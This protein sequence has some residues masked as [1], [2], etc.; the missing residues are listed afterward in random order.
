VKKAKSEYSI[1]TVVNAFGV[2]EAFASEEELGVSELS[3][4]LRLHKNNVFRILATLE[5]IGYI[6][7]RDGGRYR[8]GTR[9]L[10]L[11][12]WFRCAGGDL[13]RRG[14]HALEQ[15]ARETG[16]TVHLGVL[17]GFDVVHLDGVD[18]QNA[19]RVASRVG[20]RLP[21]HCT[22]LG[23]VLLACAGE[24]ALRAFDAWLAGG[25]GLA[26][27]T[28]QTLVDRDKLFEHLRGVSVERFALD[29]E[30]WERGVC[31]AAAPVFDETGCAVAALSVSGPTPRVDREVLLGALGRGVVRAAERLSAELGYSA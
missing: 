5:A 2:L 30:E 6:E 12:R 27:R 16:E 4:A 21:V 25:G 22:A 20:E 14:R 29:I 23:K 11:A 17:R 18:G 7:Q 28:P 26:A 31:C 10:A 19:V 15:L 24:D 1:Q 13:S 9:C 3:R 8:L